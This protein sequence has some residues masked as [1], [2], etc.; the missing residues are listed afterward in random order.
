MNREKVRNAR[1]HAFCLVS[2]V[3]EGQVDKTYSFGVE[4]KFVAQKEKR[5]GSDK[6]GLEIRR[7]TPYK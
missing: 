7:V 2:G 6:Y 1:T 4:L 5:C 3:Y